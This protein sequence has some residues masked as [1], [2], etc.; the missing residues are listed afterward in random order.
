[1]SDIHK[2]LYEIWS[3]SWSCN[4]I[5][6]FSIVSCSRPYLPIHCFLGARKKA[7]LQER[8]VCT[9]L[10]VCAGHVASTSHAIK[11]MSKHLTHAFL[12]Y[13]YNK[14]TVSIVKISTV[15]KKNVSY[16]MLTSLNFHVFL[17]LS[18]HAKS[19]NINIISILLASSEKLR[20]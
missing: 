12:M 18:L 13:L 9:R 14:V 10:Y 1:M 4:L 20:A 7:T 17:K 19:V 6:I 2:M 3:L 15:V 8:S 11:K 16:R 5:W